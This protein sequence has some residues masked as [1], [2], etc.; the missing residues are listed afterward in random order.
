MSI[1]KETGCDDDYDEALKFCIEEIIEEIH[2][3]K[4][5]D[6]LAVESVYYS[7][8]GKEIE[9]RYNEYLNELKEP[10]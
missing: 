5:L 4:E 6:H 1:D 2:R 9:Q 7:I 3:V 10:S 8:F